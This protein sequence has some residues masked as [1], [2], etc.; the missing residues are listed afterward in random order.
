MVVTWVAN[1]TEFVACAAVDDDVVVGASNSLKFSLGSIAAK[2]SG[3]ISCRT[4]SL[5]SESLE[6]VRPPLL[7][8]ALR[9]A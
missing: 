9:L 8:D 1:V 5:D 6:S 3:L 2:S 7:V 4:S